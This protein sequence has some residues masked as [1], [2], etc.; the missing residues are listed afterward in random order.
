MKALSKAAVLASLA[1]I[2]SGCAAGGA[3]PTTQPNAVR[4]A[5]AGGAMTGEMRMRPAD[6]A[7]AMT[8]E[9][10]TAPGGPLRHRSKH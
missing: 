9:M 4:P 6:A 10:K 7:G 2:F 1:L 5:D 8:G 3:L